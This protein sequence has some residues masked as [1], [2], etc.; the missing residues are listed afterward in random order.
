M[1]FVGDSS[2]ENPSA[3]V[4]H[5]NHRTAGICDHTPWVYQVRIDMC[6]KARNVGLKV[7]GAVSG[8]ACESGGER[9]GC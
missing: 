3:V 9:Q 5:P 7:R 8:S 2:S 1:R 4:A 6:G